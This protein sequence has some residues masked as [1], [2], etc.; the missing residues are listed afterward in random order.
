MGRTRCPWEA[1]SAQPGCQGQVSVGCRA[2][3]QWE[4]HSTAAFPL[5]TALLLGAG[6]G[7][8]SLFCLKAGDKHPG[9]NQGFISP[10]AG[11]E[12]SSCRPSR[13]CSG[14]TGQVPPFPDPETFW[15]SPGH[16][17]Q[18][19]QIQTRLFSNSSHHTHSQQLKPKAWLCFKQLH[20]PIPVSQVMPGFT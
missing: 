10:P 5:C 3:M 1:C 15:A 18:A 7:F 14:L 9:D 20:R 16:P 2:H 11:A 17:C 12:K 13:D 19:S 4:L 6:C 8:E